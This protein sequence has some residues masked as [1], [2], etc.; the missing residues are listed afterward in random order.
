MRGA[1]H[2]KAGPARAA[3]LKLHLR[4]LELRLP[5]T[6]RHYLIT[7]RPSGECL[8]HLK[9]SMASCSEKAFIR[10][11]KSRLHTLSLFSGGQ[12]CVMLDDVSWLTDKITLDYDQGPGL[13][14]L[15]AGPG[16][17]HSLCTVT[18]HPCVLYTALYTG[19]TALPSGGTHHTIVVSVERWHLTNDM[20]LTGEA[21]E[22]QCL[23]WAYVLS[24]SILFLECK[25]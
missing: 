14:R 24:L 9:P 18:G 6:A 22:A 4:W 5:P 21:T 17:V 10:G 20:K 8:D 1:H 25:N 19:C 13:M 3:D 2:H 15:W 11:H 23:D 7:T 16:A 12:D